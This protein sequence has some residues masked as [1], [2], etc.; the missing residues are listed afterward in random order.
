M[1]RVVKLEWNPGLP[2]DTDLASYRVNRGTSPGS[3]VNFTSGGCLFCPAPPVSPIVVERYCL[4]SL[5]PGQ[6]LYFAVQAVDLVGNTS[7]YSNE[8]FKT[9]PAATNPLGNIDV[10]GFSAN[11]VDGYDL[12]ALGATFGASVIIDCAST[13]WYDANA[14]KADL[15][16]DG[17]VDGLDLIIL[18]ANFGR[19]A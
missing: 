9:F 2:H 18:S 7:Q 16:Y 17:R 4:N 12:I 13:N 14:E 10:V 5:P 1:A 3:Y 15:N 6:T 19:S 11:R 8:V